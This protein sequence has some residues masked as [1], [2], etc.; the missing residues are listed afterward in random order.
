LD[1]KTLELDKVSENYFE[2]KRMAEL[3]KSNVEA[4]KIE[5][6]KV[7]SDVKKRFQDEVSELVADNHALQLRIEDS[8]KDR[9]QVRAMRR[10]LDDHKRRI[11]DA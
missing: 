11:C 2:S 6:E 5:N 3:H 1:A 8:T 4:L 7:V 10:D 9:E